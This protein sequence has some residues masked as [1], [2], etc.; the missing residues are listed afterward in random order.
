[1]GNEFEGKKIIVI[2]GSAGMGPQVAI[3]VVND[4]GVAVVVGRNDERVTDTVS[5]LGGEGRA[6]GLTAELADRAA[7]ATLQQRLADQHADAT[8]L[9]NAAGFFIP[10]GFL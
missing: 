7:V 6:F 4:G 8:L 10:K 5:T 3:D 2:G 9:V 1:M